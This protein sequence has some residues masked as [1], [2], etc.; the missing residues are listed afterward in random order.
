MP[1]SGQLRASARLI[2]VLYLAGLCGGGAVV[3]TAP[4]A[5]RVP[6]APIAMAAPID[7][8]TGALSPG[9]VAPV[10]PAPVT[11]SPVIAPPITTPP[12][13]SE[14]FGLNAVND[15]PL[16]ARWRALQPAIRAETHTLAL[17]RSNPKICPPAAVRF[18]AVIEAGRARNGRARL[19]EINRAVNLAIRP[20]SDLAQYGAVDVW[21]SPL[22]TFASQAGDCED[23][24]IA[25]YVA[26]RQTGMAAA[27]VRLV[28]VHNRQNG[29]DHAV[30][31]ARLNGEWLI[32]D[33]QTMMLRADKNELFMTPIL[34]L[35]DDNAAS[36][37]IA[38][39]P[40]PI[41]DSGLRLASRD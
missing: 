40:K 29:E 1:A 20:M 11:M 7:M 41:L 31:A 6:P 18:L 37:L 2:A 13:P 27:D 5:E 36:P 15:G 8:P 39:A 23:Y 24:A 12:V 35:G 10:A 33:N 28:I 38:N 17:C 34:A 30:T 22:M 19:G 26:L 9:A 14:P 16:A 4:R 21:A 25:K 32:L 3:G